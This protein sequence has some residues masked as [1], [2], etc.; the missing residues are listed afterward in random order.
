MLNCSHENYRWYRPFVALPIQFD[1]AKNS[2]DTNTDIGIGES[3]L[4]SQ[5]IYRLVERGVCTVPFL[6]EIAIFD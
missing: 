4:P 5:S 3:I 2:I 6:Y 1:I